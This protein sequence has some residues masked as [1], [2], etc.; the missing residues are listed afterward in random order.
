MGEP[1]A[2][3][4]GPRDPYPQDGLTA[5]AIAGDTTTRWL[6]V[7]AVPF[8]LLAGAWALASLWWPM[9]VDL[10]L[11][12]GVASV[13]RDGG[14]QYRD[15][16]DMHGPLVGYLVALPDL[17]VGSNPAGIRALDLVFLAAG[18]WG[19]SRSVAAIS[20]RDAGR[21]V[22]IMLVLMYGSFT[23]NETAQPDGWVGLASLAVFAPLLMSVQRG[24]HPG[25]GLW[26]A[27]GVAAGAFALIKP[28]YGLFALVPLSAAWS[29]AAAQRRDDAGSRG[30]ARVVVVPL[31]LVGVVS[32]GV[33]GAMAAWFAANGALDALLEVHL[34]YTARVYGGTAGLEL[35]DRAAGIAD[36]FLRG[37]FIAPA[38]PLAVVGIV[39]LMRDP[40]RHIVVP[41]IVWLAVAMGCAVLQNKFYYYHWLPTYPPLLFLAAVGAAALIR[42]PAGSL[43]RVVAIAAVAALAIQAAVRPI[44]YVAQW[45]LFV[46]GVHSAETYYSRFELPPVLPVYQ[47]VAARYLA[48][49]TAPDEGFAVWGYDAGLFYLANRPTPFR[50]AGWYW[51][52]TNGTP[53]TLEEYRREYLI[54]LQRAAPRYYVVNALDSLIPGPNRNV[55]LASFPE[56]QAVLQR[57][58]T[59]DT[60]VGP[61]VLLRRKDP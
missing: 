7:A 16:W 30:T 11:Y 10:G 46:I 49:H 13:I 45:G 1:H 41:Y 36:F 40:R 52:M 17:I 42:A 31:L 3:G 26:V 24:H 9:G 39:A 53:E 33:V 15:A 32:L 51:P 12:A 56:L 8:A 5:S 19:L 2:P 61:L 14:M 27:V 47:R 55:R 6:R 35:K 57:D 37:K 29:L 59:R 23:F 44:L 54:E 4:P 34:R 20:G 60:T 28:F 50:L 48:A 22:A 58:F 21:G 25:V 38:L 18:C 43:G